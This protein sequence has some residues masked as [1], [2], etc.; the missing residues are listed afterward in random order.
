MNKHIALVLGTIFSLTI[1]FV[2]FTGAFASS[3]TSVALPQFVFSLMFSSVSIG[4]TIDVTNYNAA[5][6]TSSTDSSVHLYNSAGSYSQ[7]NR[8]GIN[9]AQNLLCLRYTID[10]PSSGF[11]DDLIIEP[12]IN[13]SP[14]HLYG[15]YTQ[16][17]NNNSITY[18]MFFYIGADT[19]RIKDNQG[20]DITPWGI[21]FTR[22]H[23]ISYSW[24][25]SSSSTALYYYNYTLQSQTVDPGEAAELALDIINVLQLSQLSE[26][27]GMIN[28]QLDTGNIASMMESMLNYMADIPDIYTVLSHIDTTDTQ[29]LQAID[30]LISYINRS[31][32]VFSSYHRVNTLLGGLYIDR[33][34]NFQFNDLYIYV[35]LNSNTIHSIFDFCL[36]VGNDICSVEYAFAGNFDSTISNTSYFDRFD[37]ISPDDLDIINSQN[38]SNNFEL[39]YY[40]FAIPVN[41][42]TGVNLIIHL[43]SNTYSAMY[44][45]SINYYNK[46]NYQSFYDYVL[47]YLRIITGKSSNVPADVQTTTDDINQNATTVND[48][49]SSTQQS[50]DQNLNNV[51]VADYQIQATTGTQ[52][53][54]AYSEALF[55]ASN[56]FRIW[57]MLPL[58]LFVIGMLIR[59]GVK[60]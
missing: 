33:A 11:F 53:M 55:N 2:P 3:D 60:K 56:G 9:V 19:I 39:H 35:P 38:N 6:G 25:F 46:V 37:W 8:Q 10:N 40:H 59:W 49:Q 43:K 17:D 31:Y 20:Q 5:T 15:T 16:S 32:T 27:L 12:Y 50:L 22:T 29:I 52:Y 57:Y 34:F 26:N 13:G 54:K 44:E 18:Y 14:A 47:Y 30:T 42:T 51:P 45:G 36:F 58:I 41:M 7:I 24:S 1:L 48:F 23:D 21:R 4:S 28:T